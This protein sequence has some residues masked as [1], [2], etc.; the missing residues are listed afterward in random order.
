MDLQ[1]KTQEAH[2]TSEIQKNCPDKSRLQYKKAVYKIWNKSTINNRRTDVSKTRG[3][4]H[5]RVFPKNSKG[6]PK[7]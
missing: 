2:L 3:Q 1:K 5:L 6:A 4:I 7:S